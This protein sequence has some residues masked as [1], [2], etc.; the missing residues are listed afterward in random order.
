[1]IE[2]SFGMAGTPV[3]LLKSVFVIM[4]ILPEPVATKALLPNTTVPF[5]AV[6]ETV[7]LFVINL[8]F[9]KID[10]PAVR[11][12]PAPLLPPRPSTKLL[13]VMLFVAD[14][15]TLV[16]DCKVALIKE[17]LISEA[18]RSLLPAS[19]MTISAGSR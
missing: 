8:L 17:A 2:A 1:M 16:P 7:P 19:L 6:N 3:P 10:W 12:T 14:R 18:E 4:V 13:S 15:A 11:E 9:K 5:V